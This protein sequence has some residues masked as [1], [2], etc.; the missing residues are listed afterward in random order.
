MDVIYNPFKYLFPL[1]ITLL[2]LL[3]LFKFNNW[4]EERK[5]K[6]K[7]PKEKKVATVVED[8][9]SETKDV[10]V[11]ADKIEEKQKEIIVVSDTNYLYDR[12]VVAP[13]NEDNIQD[14]SSNSAFISD[15]EY[16]DIRNRK[17][18]IKVG[19]VQLSDKELLYKK[20]EAMKN[21]N[22]ELKQT[23]KDC[24]HIKRDF[25]ILYEWGT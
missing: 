20:I 7:K 11:K 10:V 15:D 6:E 23:P 13:T 19:E 16:D 17:T 18:E 3:V 14:N 2:I 4:V 25:C 1:L 21:E 24:V 12:F 9:K 5:I 8:K 22:L